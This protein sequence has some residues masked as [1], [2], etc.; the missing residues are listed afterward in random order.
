MTIITETLI[1]SAS[2]IN[3]STI[4][5]LNPSV[6]IIFSSSTALLTGSAILITN[7]YFSKLKIR[8]TK[9]RDGIIVITLLYEETLK[10][11]MVDKK[12]DE[13]EAS[14]FKNFKITT[15]VK[16]KKL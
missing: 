10:T 3:S 11:S 6:G 8:Y 12:I 13:K 15:L 2:T 1:G 9:L 7:E 5:I 14:E 16:E 4:A